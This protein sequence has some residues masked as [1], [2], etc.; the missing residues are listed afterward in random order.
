MWPRLLHNLGL[1]HEFMNRCTKSYCFI[2]ILTLLFLAL[3]VNYAWAVR[4]YG[5]WY[6]QE[7]LANLRANC[8]KYDWAQAQRADVVASAQQF[9]ALSDDYLWKLMPGQRLPRSLYVCNISGE[10]N[11]CPNCGNAI[12]KFGN[13]AW[14]L[15]HLKNPWKLTCPNCQAVFPKND[16]ARYYESCLDE[17]GVFNPDKGDRSLLYNSEHPDPNDPLHLYGVDDGS[18]WTDNDGKKYMFVA[19]YSHWMQITFPVDPF[20]PLEVDPNSIPFTGAIHYDVLN[21]LTNAYIYTGEQQYAHKALILL[22]RIADL[23]PD[24]QG[25]YARPPGATGGK[26]TDYVWECYVLKLLAIPVDRV[27]S[28]TR[29]DPE[30]YAFL[31]A[32]AAQ[33]RLPRPKGTRELL[34]QN[35]DDG[36]LRQGSQAVMNRVIMGNEGMHQAGLT[37][38]ALALNTN[39]ETEQWLD[40]LFQ[41]GPGLQNS[42][43]GVSTLDGGHLPGLIVGSIDRDGV[44]AECSPSY[45]LNWGAAFGEIANWLSDYEG[46]TKN[47][48]YRDFPPFKATITAP[49]NLLVLGFTTPNIGDSG[50]C[51]SIKK[52]YVYPN[53]LATGYK[54]TGDMR[55]ALAAYYANGQTIEGLPKDIFSSDP[56]GVNK[57]IAEIAGLAAAQGNPFLGGRNRAGYGLSS[58]EFGWGN[59]G[60][61]FWMY[62]GDNFG[63][64]HGHRDRLNL[65]IVYHGFCMLPEHGYPED[66]GYWPQRLHVTRNTIFHNTVVVNQMEQ[67]QESKGGYPELFCQFPEFGTVRV[68]SP[69]VY[70]GVE[71]YQRTLAFIKVGEGQAYAFDV[72]RVKGGQDHVYSLHGPPGLVTNIGLNLVNQEGGT[73]AGPDIPYQDQTLHETDPRFGYPWICNVQR[74]QQPPTGFMVDWKAETGYRGLTETD[75]L[76]LRY[77]CLSQMDDVALGD[78]QPPQNKD[79]NPKWLRYLLGHRAGSGLTSTFTGIIEPYRDN[80]AIAA[81]TRLPITEAPTGSDPVCLKVTLQDGTLDYLVASASD[82]AV[83]K[84][85]GGP[86]FA[87]AV[88]WLRLRNNRV[89]SAALTRGARLRLGDFSLDLPAAGYTG[90]IVRMDKGLVAK[91]HVW[92]DT[93]LPTQSALAGQQ[94]IIQNDGFRNAC[95]TIEDVVQDGDLYKVCLGDVCFV[96]NYQDPQNYQGGFVYNFDEGASFFIPHAVRL[97]RQGDGNYTLQ[98]T[99]DVKLTVPQ[100]MAGTLVNGFFVGG[101]NSYLFTMTGNFVPVTIRIL[102]D[103]DTVKVPKGELRPFR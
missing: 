25:G 63:E 82:T 94:M 11:Y 64:N 93:P 52:L 23:Y 18:G 90:K 28:G 34:V 68:D 73:Y 51:G 53:D 60:T 3:M 43:E 42:P 35:L 50:F 17:T 5:G 101:G 89:E 80:P 20:K 67:T 103:K 21:C 96:R 27:L 97:S 83:I 54:Y 1:C 61:A 91:G 102:T 100:E 14:Q 56:D 86:R 38:C 15:D 44:G 74:D 9:L 71:R 69:Q 77:H 13:Y 37:A 84:T 16:F 8:A 7:R 40:W 59:T 79:G 45:S 87:G 76:H 65:D 24:Y 99:G 78:A 92:V 4:D 36:I 46:Y 2:G 30:L 47:N 57:Q 26:I 6:T 29:N 33:Y 12:D 88:G 81:V 66:T 75:D 41:C 62:Y 10:G 39:P 22:D 31:N 55:A 85:D 70:P 49:W 19:Y 95:Y 32:K 48:V 72:F 98:M 58:L